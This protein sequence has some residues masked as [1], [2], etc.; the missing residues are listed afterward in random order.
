[1][2]MGGGGHHSV[3]SRQPPL[4][5]PGVS[6]WGDEHILDVGS[7]GG[8]MTPGALCDLYSRMSCFIT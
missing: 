4:G 8:C 7:G 1:M 3:Q 6:F 5:G 2:T